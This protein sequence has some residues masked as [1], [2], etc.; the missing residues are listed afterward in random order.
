MVRRG[1][2]WGCFVSAALS[3]LLACSIDG[4]HPTTTDVS[5]LAPEGG[6]GD[7][8]GAL[9]VS[10]SVV[11]LGAVTQG[12][13]ARAR[14]RV[15]N[16]GNAPLAAPSVSWASGS[17]PALLLIQNLCSAELAPGAE[18]DLRVQAV[19]TRVGTLQGTLDI[20]SPGS[21]GKLSLPVTANGI[22]P[23]PLVIQPAAGSFQDFGGVRV[24]ASAEGTF[25]VSNPGGMPSG[26]LSISF[27]RAEFIQTTGGLGEC[28]AGIT[29]L[30]SGE[31]CNVRVAFTPVER[32]TLETTF[33]VS[34]EQGGRS[35]T[36]RGQ[37]LVAGSLAVSASRLD[38]GGVVPGDTASL[39]LQVENGG[40]DAL[41][42]ASP[43][44][45][46]ADV[47]AFRIADGNCGEGMVLSRGQHCRIQLDYRPVEEGLASAGELVIASRAGDVS[48]R[49]A[50]Q[51]QALTR[52][53]LLVEALAAGQED[54]GDVLLGGSA[55][56]VFRVSNPAQQ[57]SGALTL[58]GRNGFEVE[59]L[60]EAG[61]CEPGVTE[62]ANQ[63]S[64]T[65]QVRFRASSRGAK[66][67]ALTVD[68]PLGGAKALGLRA[69]AV[70]PGAI[71]AVTGSDDSLVDFGRVTTG[72]R[73]S[74][75]ISVRNAG[76]QPLA[77]PTAQV[78]ASSPAQALAFSVDSR[79]AAAL[80]ADEQCQIVL[81]FA[82]SSVV[83][84][85]ASLD[86]A[87][88]GRRTSVLLMGEA[89]EPGRLTLATTD[90]GAADFGDVPIGSTV[91]RSFTVTNPGG[92]MSGALN[93]LTDNS[94]F[95]VPADACSV[96]GP[97]GLA[98]GESCAFELSFTPTTN[99]PTE[100]RLSVQAAGSGETGVAVTG[101]GRRPAALA[102]TTTERDLGRANLGQASGP[103]NQFTW[104]V[105]NGGDLPSGTLSV[106]NDNE[107][108]FDI[109]ANTCSSGP[110]AG[111]GSCSLTIAFAP[112]TA[113][114]RSARISVSDEAAGQS[115]PLQVTGV[116][117][118]LAAPG[119]RCLATTDCAAGVCT[120]GVCCN[121]ACDRTCQTCATGECVE[122][123]DGEQCGTSG[124]VC[125]GVEQCQLPAGG[126]CTDSTQCGDG[127][128]CKACRTGGNQCTAPSACCG[129]CGAGYQCVN[130]TC[131]C[132]LQGN[133]QQQM[134]CGGGVC[135]LN[136]AG[137]CCPSSPPPD[138]NCDPVDNLCKE[139]L[140]AS[141]CTGGPSGSVAICGANRTCSFS[142]PGGKVCNG[143]CIP[144]NQCC[145]CGAGQ[146]CNTN[147]GTCVINNGGA[148]GNGGAQCASGNCSSGV[149]C[150]SGCSSGCFP[151][152]TCSCPAGQQFSRG[153]CR[154]GSG[155]SCD[156]NDDC[157]TSCV[158]FFQDRD[159]DR[160]GDPSRPVRFCG[161]P[162][163]G[164]DPPVT[165]AAAADD[166]CDA[167]TRVFPGQAETFPDS[168]VNTCPDIPSHDYNC[169]GELHYRANM[170]ETSWTS[171]C[172]D[173]PGQEFPNTPCAQRTGVNKG[174]FEDTFGPV[175]L[176]DGQAGLCGNSSVSWRICS[177]Q[178][179]TCSGVLSLAPPCN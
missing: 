82:P 25:V 47:G 143:A 123:N 108:D 133:G 109:T 121:Q 51:G 106:N 46:P 89:L 28:V 114:D 153:Q 39:D 53:N 145:N 99:L 62:L 159:V 30:G 92:G 150:S 2:S 66:T 116:G 113:G 176:D 119:E 163:V 26:P 24:G 78:T 164:V 104:T 148:C 57:A 70:A 29:Q 140:A 76:D 35:A 85:S 126:G 105:N 83:P 157:A 87:A 94:Q 117:V 59:P 7:G 101:R 79:C 122:Q 166:C 20:T 61:A 44:L 9:T 19:P 141:D 73:A 138:C 42:L 97:D 174:V 55:T 171:G 74:R 146:S 124:G 37:G 130:G 98:D 77:S 48:Q 91:T 72:G 60:S 3:A 36:L 135:A 31:S 128:E 50:L 69:R 160:H 64:C 63:Q 152:G 8:A 65:V 52:G 131:G 68:S 151:D 18:C 110:V 178:N 84:Y 33:T 136:R 17:D 1:F 81:A 43:Q 103:S 95:S 80:A 167:D 129:G 21:S 41:T 173:D 5:L 139:C 34:S 156:S 155:T 127:L 177:L 168:L 71:E 23:G 154:G 32:G 172:A 86:L 45:S 134:D 102:A 49:I 4:R 88:A 170:G 118:Q 179:G 165:N 15:S 56:R 40:D 54:F 58:T 144:N 162:P 90:G 137:A 75:T 149:C 96:A 13:A 100:A 169:D 115:V 6:A 107:A 132:P 67:G 93:L 111:N 10:P 147:N 22:Q 11:D 125:F 161:S 175:L 14:L 16:S 120:A 142:C 27:N 158:T 38:F 12:F 112:D